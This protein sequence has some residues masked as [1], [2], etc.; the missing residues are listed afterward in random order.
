MKN[1]IGFIN[2]SKE[3]SLLPL[4]ILKNECDYNIVEFNIKYEPHFSILRNMFLFFQIRNKCKKEELDLLYIVGE[5]FGFL[6]CFSP[7]KRIVIENKYSGLWSENPKTDTLL[8]KALL[9]LYYFFCDGVIQ[10]SLKIQENAISCG[11][12]TANNLVLE[13]PSNQLSEL[14]AFFQ[15]TIQPKLAY[16][17]WAQSIHV[18]PRVEYFVRN[19]YQ[20]FYFGFLPAQANKKEFDGVKTIPIDSPFANRTLRKIYRIWKVWI[21]SFYYRVDILHI[22][23]T[24]FGICGVLTPAKRVV[25]ENAGSDVLIYPWKNAFLRPLYRLYFYFCDAVIQGSVAAQEASYKLGAR[26][27]N[28][29]I[30]ELGLN[31]QKFND[32]I[33][34]GVA[35]KKLGISKNQKMVYS[36]RGF[37]RLY[38]IKTIIKTIPIVKKEYPDVMYVFSRYVENMDDVYIDLI[39]DL[40]VEKNVCFTGYLDNEKEMPFYYRDSNVTISIPNSDSSPR[41]VYESLACGTPVVVSDLP[42]FRGKLEPGKDIHVVEAGNI[43]Q[44]ANKIIEILK[45]GDDL[46]HESVDKIKKIMDREVHS[47]K[48]EA[49]YQ[50]I[51][52]SRTAR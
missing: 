25:I 48:M 12:K 5:K 49:L 38:N 3:D 11:A 6:G 27:E 7:V 45:I 36:S 20:V 18:Q 44:T 16:V 17:Y 52:S 23:T 39:N 40:G 22:M 33:E 30:V 13:S 26:R 43:D 41:S 46:S 29:E 32:H 19:N 24:S 35:R 28:N 9:R 14:R 42:W 47:L 10:N 1:K 31:F 2:L 50:R 8:I 51:L 15:K 37:T 4:E 21:L 34:K